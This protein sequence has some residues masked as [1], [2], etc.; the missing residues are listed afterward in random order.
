MNT[1]IIMTLTIRC[2]FDFA[3]APV[4]VVERSR[5][6]RSEENAEILNSILELI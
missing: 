6:H 2:A 1:A 4:A 5:N 3:Q